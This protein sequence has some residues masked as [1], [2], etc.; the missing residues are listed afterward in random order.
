VDNQ[1]NAASG[2]PRVPE[3]DDGRD[4]INERDEDLDGEA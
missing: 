3:D 1:T 4:V 2:S